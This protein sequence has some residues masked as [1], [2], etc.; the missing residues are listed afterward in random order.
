MFEMLQTLADTRR[1]F[2]AN[3]WRTIVRRM[4][5]RDTHPVIQFMKYGICGVG[6]AIT[7]NVT[8]ILITSLWLPVWKGMLIDGVPLDEASRASNLKTANMWAFPSGVLFAYIT[9]TL[10]VFTRGR[11]SWLKEFALFVGVAALAFFPGLVVVDWLAG[12]LH[13]PSTVAQIGFILTSVVVNFVC[14]KLF[15]F[16]Q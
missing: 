2:Q 16:K 6:A 10:W 4:N 7:H 3:D 12:H 14:R 8:L 13:L 9:N 11:H 1:F 15:I 5:A